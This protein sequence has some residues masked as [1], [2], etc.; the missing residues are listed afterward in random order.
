MWNCRSLLFLGLE[1][2][3]DLTQFCGISSDWALF[4]LKFPKVKKMKKSRDVFTKV[5]II[6]N[7]P[8]LDFSVIAHCQLNTWWYF[9]F[10]KF[11]IS[12]NFLCQLLSFYNIHFTAWLWSLYWTKLLFISS[13]PNQLIVAWNSPYLV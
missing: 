10:C 11:Y 13:I 7:S 9:K 4:Y 3:K 12:Y 2:P 1:F 6:L 8:C 5:A